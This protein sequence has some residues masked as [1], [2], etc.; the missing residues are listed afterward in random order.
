MPLEIIRDDITKV[1]ADAIVNPTDSFLSGGGGADRAIHRVA[2]PKMDEECRR[3]GRCG[4]GQAKMTKAYGLNAKYVIHTVGPVWEGGGAGEEKLLADCYKN[5]LALAKKM[6]LDSIAFPIISSGTFHYPRDKALKTASS[7]IEAFLMENEM[8]VMLV[9]YDKATFRIS[10][11]LFSSIERYIDDKYVESQASGP[12]VFY[13]LEPLQEP[14]PWLA[15]RRSL[16]DVVGQLDDT[17]SQTLLRI[18]DDKGFTDVEAYKRA[19][20]DK[21]LFSKIRS[22]MHYKPSK[23]TALAFAVGLGLNL[24]E[25]TDLLRRAGFALSNSSKLDVIVQ[26]FIERG[27]DSIFDVNRALFSY[28]QRTLGSSSCEDETHEKEFPFARLEKGT[29]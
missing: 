12:R 24:D 11:E 13:D 5:S 3:I 8:K 28:E 16:E 1:H 19:N 22:N 6:N 9:V 27:S 2:G 20:I 18:I 26:F 15:P 4:V 23:R 17:F 29:E 21:K 10:D 14:S 25:T 7:T